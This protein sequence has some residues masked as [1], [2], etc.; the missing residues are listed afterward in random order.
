[1]LATLREA[2]SNVALHARASRVDVEVVI[3]AD[4]CLRVI[5]DGVGPP[6]VDDP[7]G[8]G[9]SNMQSRAEA[10]GGSVALHPGPG[11]GTVVEWR[12]PTRGE[13]PRDLQVRAGRAEGRPSVP[14]PMGYRKREGRVRDG[15]YG[16]ISW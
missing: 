2:L 4:V 16:V 8:K 5:D 6:G 12:V 9:L 10:L 3:D 13:P 15:K 7:R 11:A 14:S 1:M